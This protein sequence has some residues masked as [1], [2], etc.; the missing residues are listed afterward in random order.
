MFGTDGFQD[1]TIHQG[2]FSHRLNVYD[3]TGRLATVMLNVSSM[4]GQCGDVVFRTMIDNER[5][6]YLVHDTKYPVNI[7]VLCGPVVNAHSTAMFRWCVVEQLD[8]LLQN[9]VQINNL[10]QSEIVT[11]LEHAFTQYKDTTTPT[12][13]LKLQT[14]SDPLNHIITMSDGNRTIT[15]H[16]VDCRTMFTQTYNNMSLTILF[17]TTGRAQVT[18]VEHQSEQTIHFNIRK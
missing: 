7:D 5:V 1:F 16:D 9:T 12:S 11:A 13:S 4:V 17:E 18:I 10:V 6:E 8:R 14:F 15:L 2:L 3:A